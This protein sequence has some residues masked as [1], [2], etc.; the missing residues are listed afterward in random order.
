MSEPAQ[1]PA[2]PNVQQALILSS[3]VAV[4]ALTFWLLALTTQ[5]LGAATPTSK[6][7]RAGNAVAGV[8]MLIGTGAASCV[9][10]RLYKAHYYTK[11]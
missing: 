9:A 3:D 11:K 2:L 6:G 5:L 4:T 7:A 8:F 10:A 1:D